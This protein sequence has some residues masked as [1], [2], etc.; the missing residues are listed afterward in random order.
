MTRWISIF[1]LG[2]MSTS[3]H[4]ADDIEHIKFELKPLKI[5]LPI[6]Q[7]RIIQFPAKK[8]AVN[9][10]QA[11]LTDDIF[12]HVNTNGVL[13]LR[14]KA[15]FETH[16]LWV[17]L[18]DDPNGRM[19]LIDLDAS[20]QGSANV[21][22]VVLDDTPNDPNHPDYQAPKK[23]AAL[24]EIEFYR[25][26]VQQLYSPQRVLTHP[27]QVTR[28]PM[29]TQD[30][31]A[32][33]EGVTAMPLISWKSGER[34]VTAVLLRNDQATKQTINRERLR[35]DWD[36]VFLFPLKTLAPTGTRED[37]TTAFIVSRSPFNHVIR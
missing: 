8:I 10:D 18:L 6:G 35:G 34:Y 31:V 13:Y 11:V 5:T 16:Q 33:Y 36:K 9:F 23:P 14:A 22:S 3:L 25:F 27:P 19:V 26:A 30:V 28:V 29:K 20:K 4:A 32:L 21:V 15:P 24:D 7:D 12:S 37:S 1:L 17:Q 2:L